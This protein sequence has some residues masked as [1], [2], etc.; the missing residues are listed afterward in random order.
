MTIG[1][2][3]FVKD[4]EKREKRRA[5]YINQKDTD[6]VVIVFQKRSHQ[7][8]TVS[9]CR[10]SLYIRH[11]KNWGSTAMMSFTCAMLGTT[12]LYLLH[13]ENILEYENG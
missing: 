4:K 7:N 8:A 6:I 9:K 12:L 2:L 3:V 10:R 1:K 13:T 5:S 11:S